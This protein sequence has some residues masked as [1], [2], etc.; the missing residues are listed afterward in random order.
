MHSGKDS[1]T[2]HIQMITLRD[3]LVLSYSR[4]GDRSCMHASSRVQSRG[5]IMINLMGLPLRYYVLSLSYVAT[6]QNVANVLCLLSFLEKYSFATELR[7]S[8][9]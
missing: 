1:K 4:C 2:A 3:L 7:S 9:S 5:A 8:L 6:T